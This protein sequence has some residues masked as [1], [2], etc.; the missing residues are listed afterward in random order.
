MP[1]IRIDDDVLETL[2]KLAVEHDAVFGSPNEVLRKVFGLDQRNGQLEADLVDLPQRSQVGYPV[3][4]DGELQQ[5]LDGLWPHLS[6]LVQRFELDQGGR[7]VSRPENFV[8]IK[9]Q[10][11]ARDIAI[12]VYGR[13]DDFADLKPPFELRPYRSGYYSSFKVG[14]SAQ[15]EAAV[16]VIRRAWQLKRDRGRRV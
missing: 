11:R 10:E 1:T 9:P 4:G 2:K 3:S 14:Q 13:V 6:G 16:R 15:V 8:T 7:F 12:T 5:L